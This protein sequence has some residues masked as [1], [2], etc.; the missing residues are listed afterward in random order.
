MPVLLFWNTNP[1]VSCEYRELVDEWDGNLL[2][3]H[4]KSTTSNKNTKPH[5]LKAKETNQQN[6]PSFNFVSELS[7]SVV[8]AAPEAA[9]AAAAHRGAYPVGVAHASKMAGTWVAFAGGEHCAGLWL[10]MSCKGGSKVPSCDWAHVAFSPCFG[11]PRTPA[12]F[13]EGLGKGGAASRPRVAMAAGGLP[14]LGAA[15]GAARSDPHPRGRPGRDGMGWAVLPRSARLS[16]L[17]CGT[18]FVRGLARAPGVSA[19]WLQRAGKG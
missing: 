6:P 18:S 8:S 13:G 4:V 17:L 19:G 5:D 11:C 2:Y 3:R 14:R 16:A 12:A 9:A 15:G 7:L 1:R 10:K